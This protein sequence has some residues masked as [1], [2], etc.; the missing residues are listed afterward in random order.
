MGKGVT[1]AAG[2]ATLLFLATALGI[3]SAAGTAAP[4]RS[5]AIAPFTYEFRVVDFTM[6]ATLTFA[7][8]SATTRYRLLRPSATRSLYYLGPRPTNPQA[9]WKGT[10]AGPV[11]DVVAE[12]TYSSPDPSCAK[13]IEYRPAGNQIVQMFVHLAP[14][15]GVLRRVS[16][17]VER[18]PL[19]EPNPGQDGAIGPSGRPKCGKPDFGSW[20]QDALAYAPARLLAKPRI[21]ITGHDEEKFTD[22]GIES[23]EWSLKVVLQRVSYRK[24]DCA[25]HP[26][27]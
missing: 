16:A 9:A 23:I 5:H 22:P 14:P 20:Y 25:T 24:I 1:R 19:A 18:I 12:A 7:R 15:R 13:T 17:G 3:S 27:C 6:N 10:F 21:T 2:I 4:S 11:V 26:G 8:T